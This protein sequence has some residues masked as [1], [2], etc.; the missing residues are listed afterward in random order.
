MRY[1]M[2]WSSNFYREL[3][4]GVKVFLPSNRSVLILP[5]SG[6]GRLLSLQ[7][8]MPQTKLNVSQ[9]KLLG[10]LKNGKMQIDDEVALILRSQ[11][12]TQAKHKLGCLH[13]N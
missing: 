13:S 5:S 6:A 9:M 12:P 4:D 8:L 2:E 3:I 10:M 7:K 11:L 1:A